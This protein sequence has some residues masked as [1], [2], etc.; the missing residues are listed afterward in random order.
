MSENTVNSAPETERRVRR[1]G[2]HLATAIVGDGPSSKT[3]T[4]AISVVLVVIDA[5]ALWT[6]RRTIAGTATA[7]ESERRNLLGWT[8]TFPVLLGRVHS[9]AR[10]ERASSTVYR[11]LRRA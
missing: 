4:V 10:E 1:A 7:T 8:P 2:R 6:I 11:L 3:V 9:A 5:L